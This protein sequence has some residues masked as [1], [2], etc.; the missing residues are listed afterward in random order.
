VEIESEFETSHRQKSSQDPTSTKEV[1]CGDAPL[2]SQL[3]RKHK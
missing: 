3:H 1:G 2:S